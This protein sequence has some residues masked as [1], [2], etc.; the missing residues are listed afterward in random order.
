MIDELV[1]IVKECGKI[2]VGCAGIY[3]A[4]R[5]GITEVESFKE[6][7]QKLY[8]AMTLTVNY[9]TTTLN[10]IPFII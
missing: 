10:S 2:A 3:V 9:A 4:F 7:G 1:D 8:E 6:Q 5:Y